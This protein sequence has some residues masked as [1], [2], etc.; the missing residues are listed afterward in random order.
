MLISLVFWLLSYS[1]DGNVS[2]SI[3]YKVGTFIEPVTRFFGM[4]WQ[5]FLAFISSAIS[6]EAALGV[7]SSLYAGTGSIFASTVGAAGQAANLGDILVA[8]I[9]PA[10]ALAFIFAVTFNIPC[11]VALASTYQETHSAKWTF[12]IALYYMCMALVLSFVV[13]HIGTLIF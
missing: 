7:L 10:E 9:A 2:N 3:I 6:K 4:G 12:R 8:N 5:T 13:Y 1:S 11:I